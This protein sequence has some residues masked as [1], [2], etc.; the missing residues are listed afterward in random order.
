VQI[1]NIHPSGDITVIIPGSPPRQ[2]DVPAGGVFDATEAE[3][4]ALLCTDNFEAVKPASK[5][6]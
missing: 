5:K 6:E 1:R 4:A 3:A 2:I